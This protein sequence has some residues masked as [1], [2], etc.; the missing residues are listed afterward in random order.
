MLQ[1]LKA[2]LTRKPAQ[3][4]EALVPQNIKITCPRGFAAYK[5][6]SHIVIAISNRQA[7]RIH[8]RLYK[9]NVIEPNRTRNQGTK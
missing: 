5:F 7:E 8:L 4:V 6:G 2:F 9:K 3:E 1:K